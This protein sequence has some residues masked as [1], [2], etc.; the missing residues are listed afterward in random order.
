[1]VACGG[2]HRERV[3]RAEPRETTTSTGDD[4]ATSGAPA[5]IAR[6]ERGVLV[7]VAGFVRRPGV[8]RLAPGG[9]VHE[10]IAAA[11]GAK[12]G[13][14]LASINR[15]AT[16]VD[17]QQ[18]IV[19]GPASQTRGGE[20]ASGGGSTTVSI[21]TADV[22]ALDG[23]P[24]I[25]PVTAER[26]VAERTSGG[27]FASVDDLDRVSGIGPATIEALREVARA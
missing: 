20:D 25:G 5:P 10:A 9:R 15:A 4:V 13:A 11:G 18:V 7:D 19:A 23:L 8:Y 3:A 14:D 2:E 27:P 12:P 21:N 22:A 26:I 1:M 17:G 24:G 6:G 16:V